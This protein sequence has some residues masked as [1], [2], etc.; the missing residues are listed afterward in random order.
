VNPALTFIVLAVGLIAVVLV[1][2]CVALWRGAQ[3]GALALQAQDVARHNPALA[4][5]AV[6]RDQLLDLEREHALGNLNDQ[7]LQIARDEL[8]QRLLDDVGPAE[9]ATEAASAE[10]SDRATAVAAPRQPWFWLTALI[11]LVPVLSLVMYGLLGQPEA[12]DP[13]ALKQGV[14]NEAEV[15]PEK[16]ATMAAALTRRLEDEPNNVEGWVM[17]A[18]VQ[19]ALGQF[20]PS[21]QSLRKALALSQDD[22]L[23]IDLAEVLAQQNAGNFAGEPWA[24]IQR[25]LKADP[26]HLNGLF[27]AGSASYTE[28]NYSAALRFWERARE[29]VAADSPDAPELDRAISEARDKLGLAPAAPLAPHAGVKAA[30]SPDAQIRGRVSLA[31]EWVGKV[32]PQDTV[33][34]YATAVS[35]SRMPVAIVRTTV[36]ALPFDFVL[37]DSTA[38][39]PSAKLSSMNEVT[40]RVR[41]SKSGQAMPQPGDVM[42]SV[43]PVKLGSRNL[44]L[45]AKDVQP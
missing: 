1:V 32:G 2:L 42:G 17:L 34:V 30:L 21:G 12:L 37:D 20:E 26:R 43:S 33:F 39:N 25:V 9:A 23:A 38:M 45:I 41:V 6:Y 35:G 29:V 19:R 16:L 7:E 31:P 4:N 44:T 13:L 36:A 8:S 22:N 3:A 40:V 5:A 18:R 10:A 28:S 24:I 27:L 14:S 15:T 11:V